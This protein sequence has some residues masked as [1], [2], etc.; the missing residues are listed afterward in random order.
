MDSEQQSATLSALARVRENAFFVLE[1]DIACSRMEMERQAQKLLAMLELGLSSATT[2]S[3]PVGT[4]IRDADKVRL[5]SARL[6]DP[7][8]RLEEELWAR[9]AK[10]EKPPPDPDADLGLEDLPKKPRPDAPWPNALPAFGWGR[11]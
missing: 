11:K 10:A 6:R 1:L 7:E 9:I 2:Y 4:G 3:T 5:A 8:K